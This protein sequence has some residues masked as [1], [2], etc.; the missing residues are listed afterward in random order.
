MVLSFCLHVLPHISR[1]AALFIEVIVIIMHKA[2]IKTCEN[3][4]NESVFPVTK[5]NSSSLD[6]CFCCAKFELQFF[7]DSAQQ[8][9]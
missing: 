7:F 1:T 5:L 3:V 2:C 8:I 6:E 4:H 9:F